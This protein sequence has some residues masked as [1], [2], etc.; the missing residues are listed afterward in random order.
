MKLIKENPKTYTIELTE[1]EIF[2]LVHRLKYIT[3]EYNVA[4][5]LTQSTWKA[6][7]KVLGQDVQYRIDLY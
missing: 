4:P 1:S 2:E 3:K 7:E 5:D 6:L